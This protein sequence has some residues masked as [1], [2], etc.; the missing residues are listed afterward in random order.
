[1]KPTVETVLQLLN[2]A[3]K[4]YNTIMSTTN[5]RQG[6]IETFSNLI[7]NLQCRLAYEGYLQRERITEYGILFDRLESVRDSAVAAHKQGWDKGGK[8]TFAPIGRKLADIREAYM[9]GFKPLAEA[10]EESIP[11]SEGRKDPNDFIRKKF[12]QSI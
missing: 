11:I 5:N 2:D 12:G 9:T 8:T 4:S 3:D 10:P 7:T 6:R 1:M